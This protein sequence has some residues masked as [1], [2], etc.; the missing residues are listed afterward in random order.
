LVAQARKSTVT[1]VVESDGVLR[2]PQEI[3][4]AVY[5]CCLEALQNVAK[6]ARASSARVR[7][8]E[9]GTGLLFEVSDDGVGFDASATGYGTGLHG[10]AD[11][12]DALGGSIEIRSGPGEG[13]TVSG[14]IPTKR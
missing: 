8:A 2:Y 10:M 12:V 4:S 14:R 5:F 11:R 7:L 6:Y 1:T 13:T 9:S 3:E